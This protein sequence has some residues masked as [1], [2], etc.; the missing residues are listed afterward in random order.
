MGKKG[1]PHRK[2]TKEEKLKIIHLHL[3]GH[4]S[5]REIEI[6]YCNSGMAKKQVIF[7]SEKGRAYASSAEGTTGRT[8]FFCF[9]FC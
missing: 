5:I 8:L 1:T 3:D 4:I 6:K 2:W 9:I 7:T